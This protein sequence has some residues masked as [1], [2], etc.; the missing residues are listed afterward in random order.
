MITKEFQKVVE[1][2]GDLDLFGNLCH[3]AHSYQPAKK[4]R[5]SPATCEIISEKVSTNENAEIPDCQGHVY[6]KMLVE[7]TCGQQ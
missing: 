6:L 4:H 1:T 2:V 5:T 3:P 7:V